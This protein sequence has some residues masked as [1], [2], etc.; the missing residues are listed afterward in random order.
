MAS[1]CHSDMLRGE[2]RRNSLRKN[3]EEYNATKVNDSAAVFTAILTSS[4]GGLGHGCHLARQ[5]S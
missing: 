1:N 4:A 5:I 2:T 3:V